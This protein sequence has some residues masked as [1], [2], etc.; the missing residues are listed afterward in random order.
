MATGKNAEI[1]GVSAKEPVKPHTV[2]EIE[3]KTIF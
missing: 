1:K 3:L 2:E